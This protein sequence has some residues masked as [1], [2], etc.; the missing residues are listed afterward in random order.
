MIPKYLHKLS[1]CVNNEFRK[2][3]TIW[4]DMLYTSRVR[5]VLKDLC[6]ILIK[7]QDF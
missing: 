1:D 6:F 7:S 2:D 4:P 5:D 3:K